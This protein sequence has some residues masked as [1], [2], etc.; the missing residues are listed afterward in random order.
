[1]NSL[2]IKQQIRH[3][4]TTDAAGAFAFNALFAGT[5]AVEAT[6][7]DYGHAHLT[8]TVPRLTTLRI[9]LSRAA[10]LE[11]FVLFADGTPAPGA[12][13]L[14]AGEQPPAGV[15]TGPGGGFSVTVD[16]G[17]YRLAARKGTL[18]GAVERPVI[19]AEGQTQSGLQIRL[20]EGGGINGSVVARA[21]R[22]PIPAARVTTISAIDGQ[23][24]SS[25]AAS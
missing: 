3:A 12:R 9:E 5:Y 2:S 11:G 8:V 22:T 20:G 25:S 16:P 4:A 14:V 10:T 1:M 7:P 13:V 18:S 17:K 19:V 6:A 15:D 23:C 24:S 21:D